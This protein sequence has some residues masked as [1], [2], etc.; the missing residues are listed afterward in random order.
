MRRWV[1]VGIAVVLLV[2]VGTADAR[3]SRRSRGVSQIAEGLAFSGFTHQAIEGARL[4]DKGDSTLK[5]SIGASG[6]DGVRIRLDHGVT[7]FRLSATIAK[8][9]SLPDGAW[10]E[11]GSRAAGS[12]DSLGFVRLTRT[13][14]SGYAMR[15][16]IAGANEQIVALYRSGTEIYRDARPVSPLADLVHGQGCLLCGFSTN[17]DLGRPKSEGFELLRAWWAESHEFSVVNRPGGASDTT[18]AADEIRILP[19]AGAGGGHALSEFVL[20]GKDLGEVRI[21]SERAVKP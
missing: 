12:K 8:A 19:K 4:T 3:R 5:V 14:T 18:I 11:F 10:L 2:L 17:D 13:D 21:L 20:R 1:G 6:Q 9:D 15:G 16:A 7:A